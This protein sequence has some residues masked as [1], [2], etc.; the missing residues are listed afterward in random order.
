MTKSMVFSPGVKKNQVVEENKDWKWIEIVYD[1]K[2]YKFKVVNA[3]NIMT[4]KLIIPFSNRLHFGNN[5][6]G[7][8]F[9]NLRSFSGIL[10]TYTS[11]IEGILIPATPLADLATVLWAGINV[12]SP[13]ES[14]LYVSHDSEKLESLVSYHLSFREFLHHYYEISW[15]YLQM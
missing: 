4:K 7:W 9:L 6:R 5:F 10:S 14:P 15:H 12:H 3:S 2:T 8:L 13:H 11:R 1:S